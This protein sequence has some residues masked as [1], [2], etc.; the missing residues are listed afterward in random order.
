MSSV[1]HDRQAQRF[2]TEVE[3]EFAVLD[4]RLSSKVMTITHTGVPEPIAGRGIAATLMREAVAAA[5]AAG[6]EI[7]PACSYA[8]AYLRRQPLGAD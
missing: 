5:E 2:S 1:I 8:A 3:G 7:V 6:W 4:Y